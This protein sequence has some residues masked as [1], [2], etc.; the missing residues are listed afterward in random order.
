MS[1]LWLSSTKAL[2]VKTPC[3]SAIVQM[4]ATKVILLLR[5][6]SHLTIS[7][8]AQAKVRLR[9]LY[10]STLTRNEVSLKDCSLLNNYLTTAWLPESTIEATS[11]ATSAI[12]VS[13]KTSSS[14]SIAVVISSRHSQASHRT[15]HRRIWF[16]MMWPS[17]GPTALLVFWIALWCSTKSLWITNWIVQSYFNHRQ[18]K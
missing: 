11:Q 12:K 13:V 9:M 17:C 5:I 3:Q 1:Y 7:M 14:Q 8:V 4:K 18:K 6:K 15:N 16:Q 10:S 2:S